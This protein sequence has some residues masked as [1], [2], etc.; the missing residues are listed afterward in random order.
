[1][2]TYMHMYLYI[3]AQDT[4]VLTYTRTRAHTQHTHLQHEAPRGYV[5]DSTS[6]CQPSLTCYVPTVV[7]VFVMLPR[8]PAYD[9]ADIEKSPNSTAAISIPSKRR[10]TC[11]GPCES[12]SC[13]K[14]LS[15]VIRAS[16]WSESLVEGRAHLNHTL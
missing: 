10:V 13:S 1:M 2:H 6:R 12:I 16:D 9:L 14:T 8:R 15:H 11:D 7:V 4:Q 3:Y 5:E